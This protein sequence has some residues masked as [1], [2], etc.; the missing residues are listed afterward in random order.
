MKQTRTSA[1][2]SINSKRLPAIYGKHILF[3]GTVI[4]FGCGRY[5]EHIKASMPTWCEWYGYDPY[6]QPAEVNAKAE[7]QQADII[8]CSNV[9]NVIDSDDAIMDALQWMHAHVKPTGAVYITV[10]A[11]DGSRVGKP[12][13]GGKSWQRNEKLRHYRNFVHDAG[14]DF[15]TRGSMLVCFKR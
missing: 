8:V 13:Q 5:T 6:N 15:E 9:L 2:T 11:G 12:T 3:R 14:F 7:A 4:D 1:G 10:Y